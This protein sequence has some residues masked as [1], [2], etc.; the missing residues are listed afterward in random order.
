MEPTDVVREVQV[1]GAQSRVKRANTVN[2]LI[3]A[4]QISNIYQGQ[5]L[6]CCDGDRKELHTAFA[7][8]CYKGDTE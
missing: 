1:P 8:S 2:T 6:C 5:T 4:T 7:L 3:Y